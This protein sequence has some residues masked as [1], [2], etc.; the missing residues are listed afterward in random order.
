MGTHIDK[1]HIHN[2]V[3]VNSVNYETGEKIHLSKKDL[4]NLKD[5]SDDLR[6]EWPFYPPER[7]RTR[8]REVRSYS[9]EKYQSMAHGRSYV[10]E[11]ALAVERSRE[12][13]QDR[14]EFIRHMQEQGY[15]V[16]WNKDK[17]TLPIRIRTVRK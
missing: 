17:N 14:G 13:S 2:H 8:I 1:D 16:D 3:I 11:T 15:K 4:E 12:T 5:R 9:M 10:A 6:R 7:P